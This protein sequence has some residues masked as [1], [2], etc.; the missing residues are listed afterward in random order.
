MLHLSLDFL[1]FF[2]VTWLTW[3]F[4]FSSCFFLVHCDDSDDQSSQLPLF[5]VI[6][7][8]TVSRGFVTNNETRLLSKASYYQEPFKH[9][10]LVVEV[11]QI[12]TQ[13]HIRGWSPLELAPFRR[14]KD[15]KAP[16][17]DGKLLK[18]GW[19]CSENH[20]RL[21]FCFAFLKVPV[22]ILSF[23]WH[24]TRIDDKQMD[25]RADGQTGSHRGGTASC[26]AEDVAVAGHGHCSGFKKKLKTKEPQSGPHTERCR[27]TCQQDNDIETRP[28]DTKG[29]STKKWKWSESENFPTEVWEFICYVV[30]PSFGFTLYAA[31]SSGF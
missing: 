14:N 23:I 28:K 25:R 7:L 17:M 13:F 19:P 6:F 15:C 2:F 26:C 3:K 22:T 12:W 8:Y 5:F 16:G 31:A 21:F 11:V 27:F 24:Y 30:A 20:I 29:S 10:D 18:T 9:F 4:Q 1:F